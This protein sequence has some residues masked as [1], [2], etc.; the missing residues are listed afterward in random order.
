M[1]ILI[2]LAMT[3]FLGISWDSSREQVMAKKEIIME[4]EPYLIEKGLF[5]GEVIIARYKMSN[6]KL[7]SGEFFLSLIVI[8]IISVTV[9]TTL[10]FLVII[11]VILIFIG[12]R[13]PI[14]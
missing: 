14:C 3:G 2:A 8:L 11:I 12:S 4:M 6:D 5:A 9:T 7:T 1:N 10:I 13:P